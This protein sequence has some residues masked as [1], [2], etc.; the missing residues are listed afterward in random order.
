M[1]KIKKENKKKTEL[2]QERREPPVQT[3]NVEEMKLLAAECLNL[4]LNCFKTSNKDLEMCFTFEA[5]YLTMSTKVVFLVF[6]A[7]K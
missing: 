5:K 2:K 3:A 1:Q 4:Q 7:L 6:F